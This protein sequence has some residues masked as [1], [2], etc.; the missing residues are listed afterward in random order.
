MPLDGHVPPRSE[1][2]HAARHGGSSRLN[3]WRSRCTI[4]RL[5]RT[6]LP[7]S[8]SAM[9]GVGLLQCRQR[10]CPRFTGT[11]MSNTMT[12]S[13]LGELTC[14]RTSFTWER[15]APRS[16]WR[17]LGLRKNILVQPWA[18]QFASALGGH[19]VQSLLAP[20]QSSSYVR[21]SLAGV[22][23]AE[24]ASCFAARQDQGVLGW[25]SGVP[26]DRLGR[27][28]IACMASGFGTFCRLGR[29]M[30]GPKSTR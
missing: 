24:L 18:C 12:L 16:C 19:C 13:C 8:A 9:S 22:L 15:V 17:S 27:Q 21:Q 2:L 14:Q 7:A 5:Q 3:L 23:D 28:G 25:V 6:V 30:E 10:S 26:D 4:P 11:S 1:I 29:Y 20:V